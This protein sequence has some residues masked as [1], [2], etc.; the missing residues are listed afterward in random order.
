LR[1]EYINIYIN[2]NLI[3]LTKRVRFFNSNPLILYWVYVEFAG[4]EKNC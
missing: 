2:L 4:H 3:Y 1:Y